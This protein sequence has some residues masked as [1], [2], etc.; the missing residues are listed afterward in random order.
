MELNKLQ[1]FLTPGNILFTERNRH[2]QLHPGAKF[3]MSMIINHS[4]LKDR[5][6]GCPIVGGSGFLEIAS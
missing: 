2:N 5:T 3:Q 4:F 1:A 6:K